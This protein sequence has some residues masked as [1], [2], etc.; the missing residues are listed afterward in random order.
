MIRCYNGE[1]KTMTVRM[2]SLYR[3]KGMNPRA[4]TEHMGFNVGGS[5]FLRNSTSG[6]LYTDSDLCRLDSMFALSMN[7]GVT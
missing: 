2:R 4:H 5:P 6:R 1:G 7:S 3:S